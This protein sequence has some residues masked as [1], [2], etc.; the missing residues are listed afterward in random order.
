MMQYLIPEPKTKEIV[1]EKALP[2]DGASTL[3][4]VKKLSAKRK[5]IEESVNRTSNLT[6]AIAKEKNRALTSV[7]EQ[8]LQKLGQYLPLLF[9]L[10]H[11]A[12]KLQRG[13]SGLKIRWSSGLISQTLIQR[14]CPKFFQVDN[15]MF[16]LGMVLFLYAVKL[17][18]RAMELAS[19]DI[20]TSVKLY[21]EASGAFHHL[22]HELLPSLQPLLPPGKLPELTP[23]L[24]TSLSLLCLAEG[25]AVTTKNAEESGKSASLLSKLHY[26]VTQML[27]EVCANL[28]SR[29]NGECKDLS[30]RFL[31][32][33]ATM[34]AL[35]ELKSQKH[36]A[37][38]LESEER[39]GE[40]IGVLRRALAAAKKSKPSKEDSWISIFKKEREDVTKILAKYEKLNEVIILQKI[41]VE[42]ELPF[43]KGE[44][45]VN[46]IP[47]TPTRLEQQLRFK[48]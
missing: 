21:R 1:F 11:Y 6:D 47:Y 12:D 10:V 26:G 48:L 45:I 33:V 14:K 36:F 19:S 44:K 37:E 40:A 5:A 25:Q 38:V 16:E 23:P 43:P 8:D 22:S 35:H 18:E 46:L 41:P 4:E 24:C 15:I 29:A 17:R 20:K 30:S 34:R 42:T 2:S 28:S 32:Y 27:S 13:V 3:T 7:C 9:N 39:V 31:E